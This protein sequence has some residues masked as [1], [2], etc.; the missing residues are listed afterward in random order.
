MIYILLTAAWLYNTGALSVSVVHIYTVQG[1][2]RLHYTQKQIGRI[3]LYIIIINI[4]CLRDSNEL[5]MTRHCNYK[6]SST[7][8]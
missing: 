5:T 2:V 1:Q 7:Y 6:I 8:K 4:T 3:L